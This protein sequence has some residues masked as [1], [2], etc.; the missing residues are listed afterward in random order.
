MKLIDG[1]SI[2]G[3]IN[4]ETA[5]LLRDARNNNGKRL[6]FA[7][8]NASN[9][10][11]SKTY[12]KLKISK[13]KEIGIDADLVQFPEEV[14][15]EQLISRINELNE[16]H[17]IKG[18]IVQLPLYDH[19]KD[20]KH[21]ILNAI[22]PTKDI[23]GLSAVNLGLVSQNFLNG[24]IP[25]TVDAVLECLKFIKKDDITFDLMGKN[26]LVINNSDLIG[27]PLTSILST[28]GATVTIAN[29]YSEDLMGLISR[30]GIIISA[31]GKG[32]LIPASS[33]QQGSV[34]IDI[35]SIKKDNAIVG[36]FIVDDEF[37]GKV[38]YY[39]PVPG[40]VG[41]LTIAC[42]LRNLSNTLSY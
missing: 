28:M 5:G 38:S 25:A 6:R 24:F 3:S 35:T 40:G 23:D 9:D 16:N 27:K 36:D 42:L 7:V 20:F 14:S 1:K 4:E 21:H 30:N 22:K 37:K 18:I 26:V 15:A 41:P 33:I 17:D 19:I 11:A 32:K 39:T 31:T 13:A 2:A 10:E 8:V 12:I 34:C 29:E